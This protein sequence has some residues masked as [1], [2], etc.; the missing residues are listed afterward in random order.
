MNIKIESN[1]NICHYC[2]GSGRLKA[3]QRATTSNTTSIRD[4]DKEVRCSHCNGTG[5]IK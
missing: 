1:I 5:L 3:M 4:K 2:F